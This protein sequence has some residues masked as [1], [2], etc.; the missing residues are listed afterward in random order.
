MFK[1]KPINS[2]KPT[3]V[4]IKYVKKGMI[5]ERTEYKICMPISHPFVICK[6]IPLRNSQTAR[7]YPLLTLWCFWNI[8]L[9]TLSYQQLSS[10]KHRESERKNKN[11]LNVKSDRI[12]NAVHHGLTHHRSWSRR[13]G[14]TKHGEEPG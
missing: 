9:Q 6:K 11:C 8:T 5:S 12:S 14:P 1:Q 2:S 3:S 4:C 13:T 10:T 7:M